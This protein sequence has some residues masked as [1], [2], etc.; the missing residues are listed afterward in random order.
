MYKI[1]LIIGI[2]LGCGKA[3]SDTIHQDSVK[4]K[5]NKLKKGGIYLVTPGVYMFNFIGYERK[6]WTISKKKQL[7][8][9]GAV[10]TFPS[11][12]TNITRIQEFMINDFKFE[13]LKPE[14]D[15]NFIVNRRNWYYTLFGEIKFLTRS[16]SR[17]NTMFSI[18]LVYYHNQFYVGYREY[19]YMFLPY[20]AKKVPVSPLYLY[21]NPI[22][23]R[24]NM[25]RFYF[26]LT[27]YYLVRIKEFSPNYEHYKQ[28]RPDRVE[29]QPVNVVVF[30]SLK[31]GYKL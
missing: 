12:R 17:I 8:L 24:Y 21:I 19:D 29:Y 25:K 15:T 5:K 22:G 4:I 13:Y 7:E 3:Y 16:S 30:L 6:I 9:W 18:G 23:I 26:E 28:V 11:L 27:P 20:I 1:I 31:C 14:N 2:L 10:G